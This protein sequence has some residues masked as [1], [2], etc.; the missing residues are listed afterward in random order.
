MALRERPKVMRRQKD[1]LEETKVSIGADA[2]FADARA[3]DGK[4]EQRITASDLSLGR[5][6]RR[7]RFSALV[8]T[9]S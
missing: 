4:D 7:P 3:E 6:C 2:D 5:S 1:A 9:G 8:S